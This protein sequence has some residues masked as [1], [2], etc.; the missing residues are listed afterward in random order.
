M[1]SNVLHNI[2]LSSPLFL[3]VLIGY[4]LVKLGKWP[5]EIATALFKFVFYVAIPALLFNA[6]SRFA[7]M[8]SVDARLLFAFFGSCLVVLIIGQLV[9]RK[10]FKLNGVEQSIFGLAGIYSNNVFLGIP[11]VTMALGDHALPIVAL[12]ISFNVPLMWTLGTISAE[13]ASSGSLS[14]KGF[15]QMMKSLLTNPVVASILLGLAWSF[16]GLQLPFFIQKPLTMMSQAAAPTALVVLGMGLAEYG[17]REGWKQS[18]VITT[19][20]LVVQPMLVYLLARAIG[21]PKMETQVI[22]TLA[23][24]STAVNAYLMADRFNALKGAVAST[25]VISTAL[26]AFTTPIVIALTS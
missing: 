7:S 16:T 21:V 4:V 5:K 13:W 23:S 14:L 22:V 2:T 9:A 3:L 18:M 6:M 10:I 25:M 19:I 8:P 11:I 1:F 26:A 15:T 12:I 20:K 17:I 24:I